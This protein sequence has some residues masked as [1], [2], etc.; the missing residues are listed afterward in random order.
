MF[1]G[2]DLKFILFF[3]KSPIL[4]YWIVYGDGSWGVNFGYFINYGCELLK[5]N[6]YFLWYYFN[7]INI[8]L[9]IS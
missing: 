9:G 3:I 1:N 5:Q 8:L 7:Y 6:L 4:P 2:F